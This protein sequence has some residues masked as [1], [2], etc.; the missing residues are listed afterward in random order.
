MPDH[1]ALSNLERDHLILSHLSQV[2]VVASQVR[3]KCPWQV[4][5]EDL[6]SVGV[7]GLI[8]AIDRFDPSRGLLL[9]TLAEYRIRGAMFD[10]LRQLDP[11]PRSV[12]RFVRHRVQAVLR[13]TRHLGR[14]PDESE[15]AQELGLSVTRMRK[16][17]CVARAGQV[18]SLEEADARRLVA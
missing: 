4:E 7:I 9:K 17:E 5:I 14:Q 15:L 3:S 12:R 16:L 11:L 8:Q 6:V 2:R 13:L 10:Y 18:R 1:T